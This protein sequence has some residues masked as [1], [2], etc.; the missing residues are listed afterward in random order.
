M[1][2]DATRLLRKG[3][4]SSTLVETCIW[5]GMFCPWQVR[6]WPPQFAVFVHFPTIF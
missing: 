6:I 1:I 5:L 3:T 2:R 4:I